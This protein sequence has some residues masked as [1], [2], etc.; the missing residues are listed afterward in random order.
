[1][2]QW[3]SAV[4]AHEPETVAALFT[5]DA[6]FQGPHPYSV[7]RPGVAAYY[8]SQPIGLTA[9]YRALETRSLPP[10]AGTSSTT[11]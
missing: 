8:D 7:G 9:E 3:K 1:M 5:E 4:D 10:T 2:D 6:A 11:R